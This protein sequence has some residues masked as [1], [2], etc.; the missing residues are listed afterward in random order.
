M[1]ENKNTK[2]KRIAAIT[3]ARNDTFFL[4]R[5]INYYGAQLGK[6]NLYIYLDGQDQTAPE[7][8]ENA[9]IIH[10]ER[11]AEHVVRAE[12]R[13]LRFLSERAAE[14]LKT[15]D[16]IIGADADEFLVVDP[17]TEKTL[18]EYLSSLPYKTSV[19][20]LGMDVGQHLD[21]EARLDCEQP[22]LAQRQ[23]ALL[24]SRYTKPSVIFRPVFWGSGFHRIK[25]HNF[26]IDKNLY[27]LHFGSIDYQM[28]ME[29]L[30]DKDRIATGR[31]KHILKRAHTI[32]MIS[33][34]KARTGDK[35]LN[36]ARI[37]QYFV[38]PIFALNKPSM[39]V[40]NL[41]VKIPER[42]N[43]LL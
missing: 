3:M 29:R 19:S 40:W 5:W 27:L 35:W 32:R 2:I 28:I 25:G 15:Y 6:E 14:L 7:N 13:R 33:K 21:L 8:A 23:F 1:I 39:G 43:K 10:C 41:V 30:E 38:R 34:K 31:K 17:K 12:K 9:N 4:N 20:A 16:I 37:I 26:R 22:F 24:A 18:P 42:F 36:W 11:V